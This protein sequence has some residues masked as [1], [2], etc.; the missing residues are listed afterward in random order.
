MKLSLHRLSL[1]TG[2]SSKFVSVFTKGIKGGEERKV[3]LKLFKDQ[4]P[5]QVSFWAQVLRPRGQSIFQ[6]KK[7]K[8]KDSMK[9]LYVVWFLSATVLFP[10]KTQQGTSCCYV[11]VKT[12]N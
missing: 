5:S 8:K 9:Q 11:Y 2:L 6:R 7:E 12:L 4:S 3:V 10:A 1:L